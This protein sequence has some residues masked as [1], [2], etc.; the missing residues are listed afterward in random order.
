LNVL[1]GG[2]A[3]IAK[4]N[5]AVSSLIA[6]L[7]GRELPAAEQEREDP[8]QVMWKIYKQMRERGELHLKALPSDEGL[9]AKITALESENAQLRARLGLAS[10]GVRAGPDN[11]PSP[12]VI[13]AKPVP[14][15]P[16]APAPAA[17]PPVYDYD[18]NDGWKAYI[19]PDGSIRTTPMSSGKWW[20]PI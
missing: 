18:A 15:P 13:N 3:D 2:S 12:P 8:R 5:I 6:L 17:E 1:S 20:G 10:A 11:P 14:M 16:S 4:L 7:P 19:E 9:R